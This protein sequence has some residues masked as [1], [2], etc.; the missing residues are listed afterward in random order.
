MLAVLVVNSLIVAGL[1]LAGLAVVFRDAKPIINRLFFAFAVT[2]STWII[3]NF[4]SNNFEISY[5]LALLANHLTLFASGIVLILLLLFSIFLSGKK[6]SA[7][8]RLSIS[9]LLGVYLLSL[10]DWMFDSITRQGDVYA[11]NFTNLGTLYFLAILTNIVWVVVVLARARKSS[12][13]LQKKRINTIFTGVGILLTVNVATNGLLPAIGNQYALTNFGPLS[14][15][16]VVYTLWLTIVKHR[17]FDIRLVV[18]RS[19]TYVLS[20]AVLICLYF[21]VTLLVINN[22]ISNNTNSFAYEVATATVLVIGALVFNPIKKYFDRLTNK[23]FYRDAY[24]SQELLDTLS[25]VLVANTSLTTMQNQVNQILVEQLKCDFSMFLL[26]DSVSANAR[27]YGHALHE[28]AQQLLDDLDGYFNDSSV[29]IVRTEDFGTRY[30]HLRSVL[31]QENVSLVVHLKTDFRADTSSYGYLLLGAKK[32]GNIYTKQD[33]NVIQIISNELVI[34]VQNSLRFEE[35]EQFN[36]TLQAK[37][38]EATR[39][40]RSTNEKL[41]AMDETKDEFISM[42]SHQLRTPLTSVKG[43]VSMVLEGDAGEIND[44]QR[45]LLEQAFTS[46]QRMVYLIADLL[47]LSRLRTGKFIIEATPTNLSDVIESEVEQLKETA[48]SR[49]LRLVYTKPRSFPTLMLDE[50][51]V[52]QVIM[53]FVDNAIYYTPS[54]GKIEITL[55]ETKEA[56]EFTV[57]DN[58]IGVP[59]SEQHHLFNKFY[60]ARNAQKARPDGTGLGLFMAKKVIVAQGGAIIF[61]SSE[62]KGSTFGFTFSKRKLLISEK[63]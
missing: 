23:I 60:R 15:V 21:T 58:G 7:P 26:K 20:I 47:N 24:N 40:L 16:V 3:A 30:N 43:Y 61:T 19:M 44:M 39:K 62:G 28:A 6:V 35:I 42:A 5:S 63:N 10:S 14:G 13:G 2:L 49:S 34:S 48:R 33:L 9:L 56:V 51:K 45:K 1:L 52:R 12:K 25:R 50:T 53:N 54:G 31:Q 57:H 46:S 32:S 36:V 18:A 22:L 11:I 8:T 29:S 37:V 41:E 27:T 38:N 55:R 59:K 17:L 4:Y